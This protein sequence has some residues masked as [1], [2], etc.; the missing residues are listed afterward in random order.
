MREETWE[1]TASQRSDDD[2]LPVRETGY[3]VPL[4]VESYKREAME[5]LGLASSAEPKEPSSLEST[6]SGSPVS[7]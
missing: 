6:S 1:R 7:A 2:L 3:R 5:R 4:D